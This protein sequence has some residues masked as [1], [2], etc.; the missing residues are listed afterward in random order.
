MRSV[1]ISSTFKD[2]QAER[3]FL[4]EKIFPKLRKVIAEYGEDVQELDLRWGI[5]TINMTEEESGRLVLKVCIDAIDRCVPFIIVLL[6]E[7]YG[8]IPQEDIVASANDMRVDKY[9]RP[10]M[11]ITNLEIQYGALREES[12]LDHCVFCMRNPKIISDIEPEY[13]SIYES[14]SKEHKRKLSEL[15]Q[16][17]QEKK[18]AVVLNYE[19]AWDADRHKISGLDKFGEDLFRILEQMIRKEY[20][21]VRHLGWQEKF[22]LE[23]KRTKEQYLSAYVER[24][25][26]E[27]SACQNIL[28]AVS[29]RELAAVS[30]N[31]VK[32]KG[33]AGVGKS[34]L[35]AACAQRMEKTGYPVILYFSG[36][37]GCQNPNVLKQI[38]IFELERIAQSSHEEDGM[39]LDERLS[40][41][42]AEAKNKKVICFIDALDQL[43][44]NKT[45]PEL[46]FIRLCP[47]IVF[48]VSSPDDFEYTVPIGRKKVYPW[49]TEV[50]ELTQSNKKQMLL[51]RAGRR[52]KKLDNA[53]MDDIAEK[54][55]SSNPLYL[56]NML[57]RFFMMDGKEFEAAERLAPGMDGIH[58]YMK[59]LLDEMP[60][61]TEDMVLYLLEETMSHFEAEDLYEIMC[62]ITLSKF[63]LKEIELAEL[64]KIKGKTFA[65][66]EFQQL[67]S[68]LYEAFVQKKDG[69][70]T[71]QHRLFPEAIQ[72]H[73][74][75]EEKERCMESFVQYA[76]ENKAFLKQEGFYYVLKQKNRFGGKIMEDSDA[77]ETDR[78]GEAIMELTEED[79]SYEQYF[80]E[81]ADAYP[82]DRFAV[83]WQEK[84]GK[85]A[86]QNQTA[87][88]YIRMLH[89]LIGKE[90]I[91]S[92]IR[93]RCIRKA[94]DFYAAKKDYGQIRQCIKGM[95]Q[96]LDKL[97]KAE[98]E[99][100]AAVMFRIKAVV[101]DFADK[102]MI[103]ALQYDKNALKH[104]ERAEIL[105]PGKEEIC[106][107]K[108][109]IKENL[110]WDYKNMDQKNHPE[111]LESSLQDILNCK[112]LRKHSDLSRQQIIV[113][114]NLSVCYCD[115]EGGYF[116]GKR[117]A[118]YR[119]EALKQARE[120]VKEYPTVDNMGVLIRTLKQAAYIA[121]T[122]SRY[123]FDQEAY[124][125]CKKR[126]ESF[127]TLE[128]K[129]EYARQCWASGL[130]AALALEEYEKNKNNRFPAGKPASSD[131]VV[132]MYAEGI[133][134][135]EELEEEYPENSE[136]RRFLNK[137]KLEKMQFELKS[138]GGDEVCERILNEISPVADNLLETGPDRHIYD[139]FELLAEAS[140][141]RKLFSEMER[142]ARIMSDAS[143]RLFEKKPT[144]GNRI[145][146]FKSHIYQA[147]GLYHNEK[148]P[149]VV[150]ET[151]YREYQEMDADTKKGQ[152]K[153]AHCLYEM[154]IQI[155]FEKRNW[156]HAEKLYRERRTLEAP[157]HSLNYY[158]MKRQAGRFYYDKIVF[159]WEECG[160][161]AGEVDWSLLNMTLY[162]DQRKKKYLAERIGNMILRGEFDINDSEFLEEDYWRNIA[163]YLQESGKTVENTY[164]PQIVRNCFMSG[165]YELAVNYLNKMKESGSSEEIEEER[166]LLTVLC[167]FVLSD[168]TDNPEKRKSLVKPVKEMRFYQELSQN[169][170]KETDA[171]KTLVL[172]TAYEAAL[173]AAEG[174]EKGEL[175]GCFLKCASEGMK[176]GTFLGR[177]RWRIWMQVS[178][179][180]KRE[181]FFTD[182]PAEDVADLS[183][184]LDEVVSNL[185]TASERMKVRLNIAARLRT[186]DHKEHWNIARKYYRKTFDKEWHNPKKMT[187][188]EMQMGMFAYEQLQS[189]SD[190]E[191]EFKKQ[192]LTVLLE[193]YDRTKDKNV[194]NK[195]LDN[196][197]YLKI[198]KFQK[199]VEIKA[200]IW[201]HM[202]K[203]EKEDFDRILEKKGQEE[204]AVI[205]KELAQKLK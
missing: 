106:Y 3:D 203:K 70:W 97:P 44:E 101:S 9:Y 135:Y 170:G 113:L 30:C 178:Q 95:E 123:P 27:A 189:E 23:T 138:V 34:A 152:K 96:L 33:A 24:A 158:D 134:L 201:E 105:K 127:G 151:A 143:S 187:V 118:A 85:Y 86:Y 200:T 121:G 181:D 17:I 19:A 48:V 129:E 21:D 195:I 56:S 91:S 116:D 72:R 104:I 180:L 63:G 16:K 84:F 156:N 193:Y 145:R 137:C 92:E 4:H 38:L 71:F 7:R 169:T 182:I 64:L 54:E 125:Y 126:Y 122:G 142:Y 159:Q 90:K 144:K 140:V 80:L 136:Y 204:L 36:N 75:A 22:L 111:I 39:T 100:Q 25:I 98:R 13:R 186:S 150:L 46:D 102:D 160:L 173:F 192:Y 99:L 188:E 157:D 130:S 163:L 149:E 49:Q 57:Q 191:E 205:E 197:E 194:W 35:M 59:K 107:Q 52:G 81:L 8:W 196:P 67:A 1:F 162:E 31:L 76:K 60:E 131:D 29:L 5:D 174:K 58:C 41:L 65:Q 183:R 45:E 103:K 43:Y 166:K 141:N 66:I 78:L 132:K 185:G 93:C 12:V 40:E 119:E 171:Y 87:L 146:V 165:D 42:D 69:K 202:S 37:P 198:M 133:S 47:S 147:L 108:A 88:F 83:F 73:M 2:M 124:L 184:E 115:R 50:K 32:I 168:E 109:R 148:D 167:K 128:A 190:Q 112:K 20:K 62:F 117:S 51:H 114:G 176:S 199:Q 172:L 155:M 79:S 153:L 94:A 61:K 89:K 179:L 175:L 120:L 68:Y 110:Y 164:L 177:T 11:S 74:S 14:E 161:C 82:T 55:N 10:G 26:E 6:G 15:K 77:F 28:A 18:N 154:Y 139:A 53:L